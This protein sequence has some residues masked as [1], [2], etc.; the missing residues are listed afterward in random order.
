MLRSF[1]ACMNFG[2]VRF[3]PLHCRGFAEGQL[4]RSCASFAAVPGFTRGNAEHFL[5]DVSMAPHQA[6]HGLSV[7][8]SNPKSH[9]DEEGDRNLR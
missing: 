8:L 5:L 4:P 9:R 6:F 7:P 3:R 2:D 1:A